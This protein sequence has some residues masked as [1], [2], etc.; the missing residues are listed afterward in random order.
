MDYPATAHMTREIMRE[1]YQVAK[2]LAVPLSEETDESCYRLVG[3]QNP[4]SRSRLSHDLTAGRRLE[5]D[6]LCGFVS[7]EGKQHGVPTP[8]NDFIY[9]ILKLADLKAEGGLGYSV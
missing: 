9:A 3:Q 7:R 6:A 8:L 1:A 5:I 4:Q 2:A